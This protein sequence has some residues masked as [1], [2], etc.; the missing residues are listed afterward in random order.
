MSKPDFKMMWLA[1]PDHIKYPTLRDLHTFIGGTLAKNIDVPGFGVNGNTCAARMSRALNY[2]NMPVSAELTKSLK[3]STMVGD[4][5]KHYIFRVRDMKKYL[6]SALDITPIKVTKDFD[7]AFAG[8]QGIL[9]FDVKGWSDASGHVALWN[10]HEFRETHD[11][12]RRL[13]DNPATPQMEPTT[14]LMTLW[15]L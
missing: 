12:Y 8:Q 4:D 1:F 14:K 10:G 9:S 13:K 5:G 6:A 11:D 7:K 15:P 3:I 2:G